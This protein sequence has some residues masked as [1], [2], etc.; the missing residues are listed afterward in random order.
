MHRSYMPVSI[1]ERY[2]AYLLD[3]V[4]VLSIASVIAAGFGAKIIFYKICDYYLLGIHRIFKELSS[5]DG[6]YFIAVYFVVAFFYFLYESYTGISVG[7]LILKMRTGMVGD[8]RKHTRCIIRALIKTVPPIVFADALFAFKRRT[9]QRLSDRKLNFAVVREKEVK[10]RWWNYFVY[11]MIL[12]YLPLFSIVIIGY[13]APWSNMMP[14]PAPGSMKNI[15]GSE[16]QLNLIFMNNLSVDY[17]Y[18]LLGGFVLL[19]ISVVQIFGGSLM[20]GK[21]VS[22]SLLT[23][24]SFIEYGI[25]PHFFIETMGYVFGIMSGTYITLLILSLI[26]GY[27][28]RREPGYVGDT[29][30]WHFKRIAVYAMISVV[31]LIVAAYV[32]TY[33]TSYLLAHFY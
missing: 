30:L 9:K 1:R 22:D 6:L 26:E 33:V 20:T 21:I 7:K 19:F 5:N 3:I 27:F 28:E 15:N 8:D 16:A 31:L 24:P 23:Y 25:L 29:F 14:P 13:F 4:V 10:I 11:S 12:Y 17:Q 2:L 32:E 18:Y